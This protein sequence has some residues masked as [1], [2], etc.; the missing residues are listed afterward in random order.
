MQ[1][2]GILAMAITGA[3]ALGLAGCVGNGQGL[4]QDTSRSLARSAVDAAVRQYLPGVNVTPYTDCVINA[5]NTS[6]LVQLASVAARGTSAAAE[7]WPVVQG[8]ASRP[9]AQSCLVR[10]VQSNPLGVLL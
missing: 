3:L 6:E 7:A 5:A 4:V 10:A 8:I 2:R 9:E 1:G